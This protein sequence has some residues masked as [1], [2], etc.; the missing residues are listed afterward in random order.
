MHKTQSE[1]DWS[2]MV[3]KEM[4]LLK[5][6]EKFENVERIAKAQNYKKQK[7]LEKIE[8]DNLKTE[9]LRKE[10]AKLLETRFAVRRQADQ[11]K[12]QILEAFEGM[13][14]KGKFDPTALSTLGMDIHIQED[15]HAEK[16]N[17]LEQVKQ[18]QARELAHLEEQHKRAQ[19]E[20]ESKIHATDN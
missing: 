12:Q 11:Q 18:R 20:Q 1:R 4:D 5:R 14:K 2:L 17:D 6:E 16:D 7:I 13:K 3:K 15:A 19:H 8:F 9:H 10:K